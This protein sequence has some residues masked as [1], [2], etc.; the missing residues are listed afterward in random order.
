MDEFGLTRRVLKEPV[1]DPDARKHA[2]ARLNEAIADSERRPRRQSRLW[3]AAAA[4]IIAALVGS[5]AIVHPFDHTNAAADELDNFGA[6]AGGAPGP[7]LAD[8]QYYLTQV[9]EL[10]GYG[11][12]NLA[13]GSTFHMV[14]RDSMRTWIAADGSAYRETSITSARLSS[15]ADKAAWEAAG[16][17]DIPQAGDV[18]TDRFPKGQGPWSDS[19]GLSTDPTELESQLRARTG[20]AT[21]KGLYEAIGG[22][23]AQGDCSPELRA[24]LFHVA[25]GIQGVQLEGDAIDPLG[26]PGTAIALDEGAHR[27]ELIFDP[28]NANLLAIEQLPILPDRS[29]GPAE[30]W[31]AFEPTQIVTALPNGATPAKS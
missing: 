15:L 8:G 31:S 9:E 7:V 22:L 3:L 29:V 6:I 14:I 20:I 13:G 17:P 26:R 12:G 19:I 5:L 21:D 4:A 24:A 2:L 25:A 18:K 16:H 30:E 28:S 10:S 27:A 1:E 23:L 11:Q